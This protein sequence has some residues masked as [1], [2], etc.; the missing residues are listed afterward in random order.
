MRISGE[1][2]A[3]ACS[4]RLMRESATPATGVCIDSRAVKP[5]DVFVALK[6]ERFDGHDFISD[7]LARGA[8]GVLVDR[9]ECLS[10]WNAGLGGTDIP[11]CPRPF[12]VLVDDTTA[13]LGKWAAW[14]R[15]QMRATVIGVTGSN[16]KTTTREMIHHLLSG[17]RAGIRSIKSFNNSIGLPLTLLGIEPEHEFAVVEV[18]TS[19]P[20]EIDQLAR[21]AK[22]DL[23]VITLAAP[24][25]LTGLGSVEGVIREKTDLLLS[26]RP[27]GLAVVNGDVPGLAEA[28]RAKLPRGG[29]MITFGRT[30]RV[31]VRPTSIGIALEGSRFRVGSGEFALPVPG[32]HNVT[33]ATA[34]ITVARAL[35]M[36]D[37]AIADRWATFQLPDH[38][39]QCEEIAGVT[40]VDDAYNA[41]PTSMA[42]ALDVLALAPAGRRR[43]FA[44]GDM[45]ELGSDAEQYHRNLGK[46]AAETGAD[47]LIAVGPMAT[48]TAAGAA[49][50]S[51]SIAVRTYPDSAVAGAAAGEWLRPGD[52]VM[53]KG[54]RG[55]R[56]ERLA[57]GIRKSRVG[58]DR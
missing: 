36:T 4:G 40:L 34:A 16:G 14:H 30:E 27:G 49:A 10:H 11:A 32:P 22:P 47:L 26:L 52:F 5:G 17:S 50:A 56:M 19:A 42:A 7:V 38:R 43:V 6:G 57:E 8:A 46:R 58:S 25:H 9:Q 48:L 1:Q 39:L 21:L 24:C 20:G 54:S 15:K 37:D 13:A 53:L 29:R 51:R 35:G 33:N 3:T 45:L 31:D 41:N 23:A 18:G 55:I 44:A 28:A 2:L 12:A